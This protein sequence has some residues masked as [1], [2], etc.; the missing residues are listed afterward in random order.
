MNVRK[1]VIDFYLSRGLYADKEKYL[2]YFKKKYSVLEK[3]I[4]YVGDDFFDLNIMKKVKYSFCT[5][6]AP[7][8]IKR[9]CNFI[10]KSLGGQNVICEIY[11]TIKKI[12]KFKDPSFEEVID[13]DN[14]ELSTTDMKK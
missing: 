3:D 6:D 11:E 9:N 2:P 14:I 13:L 12:N 4:A 1:R 7:Q 8:I 5:A 10:L